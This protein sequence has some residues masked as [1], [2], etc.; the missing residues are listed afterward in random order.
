MVDVEVEVDVNMDV[1]VEVDVDVGRSGCVTGCETK[2]EPQL[3]LGLLG[4]G[5]A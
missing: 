3:K 1:D 2:P 4:P 5:T